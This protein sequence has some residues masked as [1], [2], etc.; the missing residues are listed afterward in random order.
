MQ[1]KETT[2]HWMVKKQLKCCNRFNINFLYTTVSFHVHV[3]HKV[4][5]LQTLYGK[6]GNR[7]NSSSRAIN[8][9]IYLLSWM[10]SHHKLYLDQTF[11]SI[12]MDTQMNATPLWKDW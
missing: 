11:F 12:E 4:T 7:G 10:A 6:T 1:R 8:R 3:T 5:S 9:F 2:K